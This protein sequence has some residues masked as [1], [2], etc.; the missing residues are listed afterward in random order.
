[1]RPSRNRSPE[2]RSSLLVASLLLT[3]LT[4]T[5][6]AQRPG[7]QPSAANDSPAAAARESEATLETELVRLRVQAVATNLEHPW[8]IASLPDGRLLVTERSGSLNLIGSDGQRSKVSGTPKVLAKGQGGM[9]DVALHPD[10]KSNSYVYL[11]FAA[12]GPDGA[13]TT[14]LGR[15]RLSNGTLQDFKTLFVQEPWIKNS[16]HFGNRIVFAPDGKLFLA[17]GERFLFAPAQNLTDHLGTVVR[18]NDDGSVPKDNPFVGKPDAK[19]E[20]WSYG[21]RNIEAAAIHPRSGELWVGEMGPKGGDELN[22]VKA[23]L[24]YG[25]PL[26]SWGKNYEG[27]EIPDPPTRPDLTDC[28]KHWTPVISPCGM[29]FYSGEAVPQWKGDLLIGGLTA[30]VL[31]RVTTEGDKVIAEERIT[32]GARIRDVEQAAD[33]SIYLL[34]DESDG[35]VLRLV[36]S[37]ET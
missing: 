3:L 37:Q 28:I 10:F 30:R 31:V 17:L 6:C 34:T 27:T 36:P 22:I 5:A 19:P 8:G 32:L 12:P 16:S 24:N 14:A 4:T 26:V 7:Q 18:L 15:G 9:M 25:W 11:T 33:G 29:V 23:G 13:S 1:M 20:I 2:C 35:S 21:H